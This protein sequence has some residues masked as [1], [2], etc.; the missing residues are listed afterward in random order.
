[1]GNTVKQAFTLPMFEG[2]DLGKV[3][4]VETVPQEKAEQ[5][6]FETVDFNDP[7][8]FQND[9]NIPNRIWHW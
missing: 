1:M 6:T 2:I 4:D 7:N 5:F 9:F 3:H 8:R